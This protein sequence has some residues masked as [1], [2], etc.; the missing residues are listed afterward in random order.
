MRDRDFSVSELAYYR[1]IALYCVSCVSRVTDDGA[2]VYLVD[3]LYHGLWFV[4]ICSLLQFRSTYKCWI[5]L[6]FSLQHQFLLPCRH[7]ERGIVICMSVSVGAYGRVFHKSQ[8][9]VQQRHFR[10]W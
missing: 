5:T 7:Y 4:D 3:V 2:T 9:V 10:V 6:M 8:R 1:C